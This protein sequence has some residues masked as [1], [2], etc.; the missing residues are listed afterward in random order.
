M[1]MIF[2][3]LWFVS[4]NKRNSYLSENGL[5]ELNFILTLLL[6]SRSNLTQ[7]KTSYH[8]FIEN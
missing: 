2:F 5:D 4:G 1:F 6:L 8:S 3:Y 7:K